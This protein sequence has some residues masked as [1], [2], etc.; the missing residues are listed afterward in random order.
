MSA[1]WKVFEALLFGILPNTVLQ[2]QKKIKRIC[3]F[4]NTID[5]CVCP[6]HAWINAGVRV[7]QLLP[8]RFDSCFGFS[9]NLPTDQQTSFSASPFSM[10]FVQLLCGFYIILLLHVQWESDSNKYKVSQ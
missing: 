8:C 9:G 6:Q 5:M 3:D 1:A 2:P 4:A 10:M 7:R